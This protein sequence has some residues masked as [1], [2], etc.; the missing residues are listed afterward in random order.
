MKFQSLSSVAGI[1]K[2]EFDCGNQEVNYFLIHQSDECEEK[3][4]ARVFLMLSDEDELIGY[5]TLS[6]S[7]IPLSEIPNKYKRKMP[8]YPLPAILIGQFGIDKKWQGQ[9]LSELLTG[10]MYSRIILSYNQSASAFN[11]IIVETQAEDEKA[12][13][14]WHRQ[15]FISFKK[16]P[17]SLFIPVEVI[18][19]EFYS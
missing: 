5:Y 9:G 1:N 2:A 3:R 13:S 7:K 19:R 12:R 14:F 6:N 17:N 10:D 15:G 18:E 4:L 8:N 16:S 11:V